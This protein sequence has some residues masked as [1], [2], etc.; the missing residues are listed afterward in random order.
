MKSR[1]WYARVTSPPVGCSKKA[2]AELQPVNPT[3]HSFKFSADWSVFGKSLDSGASVNENLIGLF[4]A[5]RDIF[6]LRSETDLR[7]FVAEAMEHPEA[8][9]VPIKLYYADE[10]DRDRY[11]FPVTKSP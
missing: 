9:P 11:G 3:A 2:A 6:S 4:R 10:V 7:R 8:L 1:W 5:R